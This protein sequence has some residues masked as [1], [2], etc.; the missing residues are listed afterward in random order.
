MNVYVKSKYLVYFYLFNM[1]LSVFFLLNNS[2]T[3]INKKKIELWY[4]HFT[5][6]S[7]KHFSVLNY[8]IFLL[9][10][11]Q[12]IYIY[13]YTLYYIVLQRT[14]HTNKLNDMHKLV[15]ITK[16]SQINKSHIKHRLNISNYIFC[17][18]SFCSNCNINCHKPNETCLNQRPPGWT[19]LFR[20]DRLNFQQIQI[21][22]LN[23]TIHLF[24]VLF[25]QVPLYPS[26]L[27][28]HWSDKKLKATN[29]TI[30]KL[31]VGRQQCDHF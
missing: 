31:T 26:R 10:A 2:L 28:C 25:R 12:S 22:G 16:I 4:K 13:I 17:W 20:I 27:Q 1:C 30:V 19:F 7:K 8:E 15:S 18:I 6:Y 23:L 21:L 24:M 3:V 5:W 14:L 11:P 29:L 9:I